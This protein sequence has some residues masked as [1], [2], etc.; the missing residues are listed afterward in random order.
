[1]KKLYIVGGGSLALE[2]YTYIEEIAKNDENIVFMG[3]LGYEN[4]IADYK[5]LNQYFLGDVSNHQ[6]KEDEFVVIGAGL[7][8]FRKFIFEYLIRKNVNFYTLIAPSCLISPLVKMGKGNIFTERC[9][10]TTN[11]EIGNGNL[12]NIGTIVGHDVIVGDFN[13]IAP[14]CQ[15]LGNVSVGNSNFIGAGSV[16]LPSSKIGTNNKVAPLS[17]I[18]KGCKNNSYIMGNPAIK[19]GET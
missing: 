2:C 13:V 9:T 8:E 1:M 18:Y 16:L 10:L 12:F 19:V 15:L 4:H 7:P 11:I 14:Y 6:F 5:T 17:A 3:F